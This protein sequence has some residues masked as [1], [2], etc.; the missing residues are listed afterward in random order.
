MARLSGKIAG[1]G[2]GGH[3]MERAQTLPGSVGPQGLSA[4]PDRSPRTHTPPCPPGVAAVPGKRARSLVPLQELPA[5]RHPP[6]LPPRV[7]RAS[8][9]VLPTLSGVPGLGTSGASPGPHQ[10]VAA[11]MTEASL[12]VPWSRL[13]T[14][15]GA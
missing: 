6:L 9:L 2:L 10:V 14:F 4:E 12:S 3:K 15:V 5:D 13:G 1:S 7:R 11:V 8:L